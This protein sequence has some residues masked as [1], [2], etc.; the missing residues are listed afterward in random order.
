MPLVSVLEFFLQEASFLIP[1]TSENTLLLK[2]LLTMVHHF[3]QTVNGRL[4]RQVHVIPR[5]MIHLS[6]KWLISI[7]VRITRGLFQVS[8]LATMALVT[9]PIAIRQPC[10]DIFSRGWGPQIL[11]P[12]TGRRFWAIIIA[13]FRWTD[14]ED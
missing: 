9:V 1:V 7:W 4:P 6:P 5:K 2:F 10:W 3:I 12:V 14:T 11:I 13:L 8:I